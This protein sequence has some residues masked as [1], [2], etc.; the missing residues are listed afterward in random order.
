MFLHPCPCPQIKTEFEQTRLEN[1]ENKELLL[2]AQQKDES[3]TAMITELT[4][5]SGHR[6]CNMSFVML[7]GKGVWRNQDIEEKD[8]MGEKEGDK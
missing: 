6:W 7:G 5:V 4:Q 3:S 8:W 1:V 2:V